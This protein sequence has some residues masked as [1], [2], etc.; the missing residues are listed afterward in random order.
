MLRYHRS[1]WKTLL[2]RGLHLVQLHRQDDLLLRRL[3]HDVFAQ[4]AQW[5]PI[6][7]API[8]PHIPVERQIGHHGC[9]QCELRCRT[10]AGEG[11]HLFKDHG[12]VARVRYWITHTA[13]E[14]CLKEYHAFDKLQAHLRRSTNCR[15]QMVTRP[16]RTTIQPGIGSRDNNQRRAQHD[17]LLP[18]QQAE[19][20][21]HSLNAH[22]VQLSH[23]MSSFMK[24]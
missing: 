1:Y 2:Q 23:I 9:M 16:P 18:A 10:K 24:V 3:H 17:D 20:P 21:R 22:M 15:E 4:L 11:A 14:V 13:C 8:R 19:G 5:G 6:P 12:I 7:H